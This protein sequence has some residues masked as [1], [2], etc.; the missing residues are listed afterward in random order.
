[1]ICNVSGIPHIMYDYEREET[2]R[3]KTFHSMTMQVAPA[4]SI[5]SKAYADI[6]S[7]YGWRSFSIIYDNDDGEFLF[8]FN[9]V[10]NTKNNSK[11][12]S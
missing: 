4:I 5:I 7:S 12:F 3:E 1:M 10:C 2:V 9:I 8:Y 11:I 6:I